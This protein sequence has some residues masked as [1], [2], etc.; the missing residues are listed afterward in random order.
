MQR[1]RSDR[2]RAEQQAL[3]K[4]IAAQKK[5]L[6][7]I[8][9][10]AGRLQ[11]QMTTTQQNL[12]QLSQNV[13]RAAGADRRAPG[14]G[15]PGP[16]PV[17][18]PGR[19]P[20]A[21]PDR[22]RQLT[23]QRGGQA[24]R[25]RRQ[26]QTIL[27]GRLVAAYETDQTPLLAQLLTSHSLTDVLSDVS[28]YLEHRR[29]GPALAGQIQHDQTDL[30]QMRQRSRR[31]S[32]AVETA[33]E[34]GRDPEAAARR[35]DAASSSRSREAGLVQRAVNSQLAQQQAADAK[36]AKNK[37]AL[38]AAIQ[39]NG[40]ASAE[41]RRARSKAGQGRGR[42]RPHPIAIQRPAA[43]ADGRQDQ[44]G[45]RLHRLVRPSRGSA[46]APTSIRASTSS[47]RA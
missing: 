41:A 29:P 25:A 33:G 16:R 42:Q 15:R 36:L 23:A 43:V 7:A 40:A 6:T 12:D 8:G 19:P 3:D 47:R 20:D 31:P 22:A 11:T 2:R 34:A 46:T 38:A 14:P 1:Q 24:A 18:Q 9:C 5:Q 32:G 28:Y 4:L 37:A 17:R 21:S 44:P 10:P 27:A 45:V 26:R 39:S 30:A 35:R 13:D